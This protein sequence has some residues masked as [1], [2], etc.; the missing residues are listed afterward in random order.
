MRFRLLSALNGPK[1]IETTVY[2][3]FFFGSVFKSP[4]FH[5][6]II[7][8]EHFQKT[9]PVVTVFISVDDF[10]KFV[11][12]IDKNVSK[13]FALSYENGLVKSYSVKN[14]MPNATENN[15]P[16]AFPV[17]LRGERKSIEQSSVL[18]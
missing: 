7:E 13:K 5:L 14:N 8:T 6:S 1:T 9:P 18:V 16:A 12:F 3:G 10:R 2:D 11:W 17:Q 15:L 4:C